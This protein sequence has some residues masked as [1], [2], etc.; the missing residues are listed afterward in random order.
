MFGMYG[1]ATTQGLAEKIRKNPMYP[2][3]ERDTAK[4]YTPFFRTTKD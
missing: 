3:I 1:F 2:A 4:A